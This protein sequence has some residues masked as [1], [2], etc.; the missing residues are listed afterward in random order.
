[1]TKATRKAGNDALEGARRARKAVQEQQRGIGRITRGDE[2]KL[3]PAGQAQ[4]LF[5]GG[6][7]ACTPHTG[8]GWAR[9]GVHLLCS[10]DELDHQGER[11]FLAERSGLK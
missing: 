3:G 8:P 10:L 2:G 1:M 6:C 7:H 9:S 5:Y 11:Y 4:P